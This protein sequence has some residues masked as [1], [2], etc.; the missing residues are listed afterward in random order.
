MLTARPYAGEAD[1]PLIAGLFAA[2][3]ANSRHLVDWTWRFSS[4]ALES[5]EDNRLWF[6]P[7]GTLA[8][9]AAWQ[10]PWAALDFYVRP[11]PD[12]EEVEAA[13]SAWPAPRFRDLDRE[14]GRPL[15]YWAEAREDDAAR[16]ALLA[17]HGFTLDDD[18][19]YLLLSRSLTEPIPAPRLPDG[20]AIRPLAGA[21]EAA[22]YAAL[23]RHAFD[24]ET[25]TAEWRART[26]TMPPYRP[27]LDLVAVAPGGDLA[28]FCV[29]WLDAARRLAQIEPLGVHPDYRGLGLSGALMHE[30]FRRARD[31]GAEF[32][33]VEP[34]DTDERAVRAYQAVGYRPA[35]RSLRKGQWFTAE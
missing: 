8:G 2:V 4:P 11:G 16:L 24:S 30:F 3:P 28:G 19:G 20:F 33:L 5:P 26:L 1:L 29:G 14:R 9:F 17:R 35:H 18:Y 23:H 10:A 13:I 31:C 25:M 15:P 34:I 7:D 21:S 22:A 12:Q 6:A 27:E 32:A